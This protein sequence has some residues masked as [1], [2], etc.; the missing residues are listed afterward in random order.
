MCA[1]NSSVVKINIIR[2]KGLG[3]AF[4]ATGA[5]LGLIMYILTTLEFPTPNFDF[6]LLTTCVNAKFYY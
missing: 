6:H 3:V 5:L 4:F 2:P 1:G